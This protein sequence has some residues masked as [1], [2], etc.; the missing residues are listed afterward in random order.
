MSGLLVATLSTWP[1][2]AVPAGILFG[3]TIVVSLVISATVVATGAHVNSIVT[4]ATA[5]SNHCHP[6]RAIIY[7]FCQLAGGAIG[8]SILHV[9]LGSTLAY[10][11]HN[12]GCWIDPEGEV[13][14]WQAALIE[15]TSSFVILYAMFLSTG[16]AC[17]PTIALPQVLGLRSWIGSPPS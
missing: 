13:G 5:F 7:I 17:Q 2:V 14:V 3:I 1:R 12:G 4:I 16:C 10:K 15:F 9:A 6:V 11:V 8:G